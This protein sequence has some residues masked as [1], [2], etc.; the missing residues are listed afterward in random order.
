MAKRKR[1]QNNELASN[2]QG[3]APP[4]AEEPRRKFSRIPLW[5]WLLIF[6]V[7]LALSEYMFSMVGRTFNM[8]LFPVV[9][10]AF[11]IVIM[12]RAGWPILKKRK[13]K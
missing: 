3:P 10:I 7:P 2:Q 11:W 1:R 8:I 13:P 4:L 5:G 6:L 9:W 12:Q